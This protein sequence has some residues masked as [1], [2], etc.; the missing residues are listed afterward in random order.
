MRSGSS[1]VQVLTQAGG[2]GR[3]DELGGD[4]DVVGVDGGVAPAG[5]GRR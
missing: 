2:M 4:A 3:V 5:G 1:T